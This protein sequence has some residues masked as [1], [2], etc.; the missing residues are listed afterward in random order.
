MVAIFIKQQ[1]PDIGDGGEIKHAVKMGEKITATRGFPF[2]GIAQRPA[3]YGNKQEMPSTGK[4][5]SSG[6]GSLG[7]CR[8]M[9]IAIIN[10]NGRTDEMALC[11]G[12]RPFMGA[13][14]F[15]DDLTGHV[16]PPADGRTLAV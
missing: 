5:A 13:D 6:F 12:Q 3:V 10:I 7:G 4:M 1:R 15:V 11:F 9:D 16:H 14:D 8:K 2:Q